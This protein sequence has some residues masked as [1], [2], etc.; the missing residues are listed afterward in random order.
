M[1]NMLNLSKEE[2]L[3]MLNLRKDSFNKLCLDKKPLQNLTSR[4][5]VVLDYSGSMSNLYRN[6][7]VQAVL[8]RLFPIA[9]QFDDN[10]EMELWIFDDRFHRLDNITMDN[11]YGYIEREVIRKYDM[12]CTEYAPV[13]KDIY[14]KYMLEEPTTLPNYI[15]FITDGDNSDKTA[16][17]HVITEMSKYPIFIQF[18]GIGNAKMAYLEE[19]D[20]MNGRYVDNANFFRI[21]DINSENDDALYSKLIA[22]Y[23][24]WLEY[25]QVKEMIANQASGSNPDLFNSRPIQNNGKKGFFSRFF[26]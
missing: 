14:S 12:G 6:G 16:A 21:R 26:Q 23:P 9:L 20:N 13:L 24:S 8:E 17:T 2:S 7:T 10:G 15:I 18:V 25:P 22:E 3:Q 19:L 4:V 5:G 11:Y 1:P